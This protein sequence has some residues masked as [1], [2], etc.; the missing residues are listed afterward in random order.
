LTWRS[1]EKNAEEQSVNKNK[2]R[3]Q[4]ATAG[5]VACSP[6]PVS[7]LMEISDQFQGLGHR[8]R[9]RVEIQMQ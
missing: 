9:K 6:A 5:F 3:K 4:P 1:S 2:Q 8:I 7:K